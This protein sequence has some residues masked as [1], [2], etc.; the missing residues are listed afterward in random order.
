MARLVV[1]GH[2]LE[3]YPS[4]LHMLDAHFPG[5]FGQLQH[6][7][8]FASNF[9]TSLMVAATRCQME[10]MHQCLR[11]LKI[12]S[13]YMRIVDGITPT[14]GE[15]LLIHVFVSISR[16][17][18]HPL[19]WCLLDM[20]PQ[21]RTYDEGA[22]LADPLRKS[23]KDLLGFHGL[24]CSVDKAHAT[25]SSYGIRLQDRRL[26]F[27]VNI[28]DGAIEGPGSLGMGA[29]SAERS[30]LPKDLGWGALDGFHALD[31]A[32]ENADAVEC[33]PG[34]LV[35]QFGNG[36]VVARAI[37]TKYKFSW[38]R[39]MAP[40]SQ[41]TRTVVYESRRCP[42]NLFA[43]LRCIVYSLRFL[44]KEA[45][46]NV[47]RKSEREGKVPRSGTGWKTKEVMRIRELG[48]TVLDPRMLIFIKGRYEFRMAC[49]LS[50]AP[51]AQSLIMSGFEKQLRL[52][53][54]DFR[55]RCRVGALRALLNP[56]NI[57][58]FLANQRCLPAAQMD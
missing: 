35:C 34:G 7:T 48:R 45:V 51:A 37:A 30:N 31:K 8:N 33:R 20:T 2:G 44:E 36:K 43:N 39:P 15:S 54:V 5:E 46:T 27:A 10:H 25:E 32:G 13:D 38:R 26:R 49:L 53:C 57:V 12:P 11:A 50:Y 3:D 29:A 4:W 58:Q 55:M 23:P 22:A 16:D 1:Q 47:R 28:A 24:A 18:K 21:G 17:E 9:A 56:L 42:P 41:G 52:E 14:N 19:K 6:S 40:H